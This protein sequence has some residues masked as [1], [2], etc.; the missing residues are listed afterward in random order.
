MGGR[1]GTYCAVSVVHGEWHTSMVS[2]WTHTN[3]M[4]NVLLKISFCLFIKL[5]ICSHDQYIYKNSN[6]NTMKTKW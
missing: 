2:V 1:R 6:I 4:S 3:P 5:T